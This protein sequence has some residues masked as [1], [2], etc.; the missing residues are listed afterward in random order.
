M[1]RWHLEWK[2]KRR[3]SGQKAGCREEPA[4]CRLRMSA[5][6]NSSSGL[7]LTA[8]PSST[9]LVTSVQ[10]TSSTIFNSTNITIPHV[11][12]VILFEDI[13][14]SRVRYWDLMLLIPNVLFFV[15]LLWKLPSARAK[16]RVTSSP[17]FTTFYILVFVVAV[18]G[19]TRAIVSMTVSSSSAATVTDKVLWEITR[20][21][22]L[23]IELSVVILGIAF[24]HL[25]SKSS[26]KRV[27]AITAVSSLAYSVTQG[28]L[29]ILYPDAHLSAEDFNIYGHG[30][31]HFWLASSCFFFLVY[32]L[33]SLLPKTPLKDRISLPS[34]KSFYVYAVILAALNLVQGIG[35]ALL[36]ADII[37]GLCL[38]DVT[39]FLYF[40]LFAPLMY[41]AF[42]K[43]FF[44]SEPKI[45]FS[46]KS[47]VDDPDETEVHL[48]HPYAVAKKEGIDTGF[49]SNTQ[50]DTTAYLDDVASMPHVVGSINSIDS[51]RW[52]AINA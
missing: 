8:T 15:F 21:F 2:R 23:A 20:F 25:E 48:P 27:L 32:T 9:S 49:Y 50:I 12:L 5:D 30:G 19:I 52:K 1:S 14:N 16:I 37:N 4:G 44:G 17:I 43:G 13:G 38:V 36:C 35:S 39:T 7:I 34:R 29:E 47:Q 45:L 51:D 41:V 26:V 10:P 24:G 28:T 18:V 33:V 11:C 31:R 3:R 40:S 6:T 42:L 22:L 46:Y